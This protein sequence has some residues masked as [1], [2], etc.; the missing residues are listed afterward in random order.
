MPVFPL[1]PKLLVKPIIGRWVGFEFVEPVLKGNRK[2]RRKAKADATKVR[3][4][5]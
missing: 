4:K 2:A 1:H 3:G 5:A